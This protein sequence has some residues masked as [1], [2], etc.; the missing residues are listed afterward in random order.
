[1]G[2]VTISNFLLS[3]VISL[4][5]RQ[6]SVKSLLW[7]RAG[8]CQFRASHRLS[9]DCT[10]ETSN[11]TK[12]WPSFLQSLAAVRV[13]GPKMSP[14]KM[15]KKNNE[16]VNMVHAGLLQIIIFFLLA[17]IIKALEW[18]AP[19]EEL[20]SRRCLGFTL[21]KRFPS[22]L[23]VNVEAFLYLL[24]GEEGWTRTGNSSD[25]A[26]LRCSPD[27][28]SVGLQGMRLMS[29]LLLSEEI[30]MFIVFTQE[31]TCFFSC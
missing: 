10:R 15:G 24:L 19:S 3:L 18:G 21:S 26:F 5:D 29:L 4:N 31:I 25:K 16:E 23:F 11:E 8:S 13:L 6:C 1:M 17:L 12:I 14:E 28:D 2:I 7:V 20:F 27:R 30:C 22:L 9:A